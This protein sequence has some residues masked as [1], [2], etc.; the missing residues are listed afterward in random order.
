[1]SLGAA[2]SFPLLDN[3]TVT[4]PA[5]A[6]CSEYHFLYFIIIE[7]FAFLCRCIMST[8]KLEIYQI[9]ESNHITGNILP[10]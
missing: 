9:I 8:L 7:M 4:A 5:S 3:F 10:L 2:K 1:M 6:L